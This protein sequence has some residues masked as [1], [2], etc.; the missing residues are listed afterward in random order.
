MPNDCPAVRGSG[1]RA[2]KKYNAAEMVSWDDERLVSYFE[3]FLKFEEEMRA[4][5]EESKKK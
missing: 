5:R 4:L 1:R 3:K 2:P